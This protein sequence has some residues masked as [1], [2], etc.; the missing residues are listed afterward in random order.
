MG[1]LLKNSS[2]Y[3]AG[4]VFYY[5][6]KKRVFGGVFLFHQNEY[7]LI[8][9]S[10]ELT[11]PVRSVC[12]NDV[13]QSALYTVAWFSDIELLMPQR[14]HI[15]GTITLDEDY[16]NRAGLLIDDQSVYNRNVG[17]RETW[18]HGFRSFAISNAKVGDVLSNKYIPK[19][20]R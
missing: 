16:S 6:S 18:K 11:K 13:L 4:D 19:T 20:W 5:I 3:N 2:N 14:L 12:V 8:A 15:V 10:E 17:Q 1:I 9:L 7:Y